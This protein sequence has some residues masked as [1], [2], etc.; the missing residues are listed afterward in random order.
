M[1][2]DCRLTILFFKRYIIHV[3]VY[4]FLIEKTSV[5]DS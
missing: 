3:N 5:F 4:M 2:F 1:I